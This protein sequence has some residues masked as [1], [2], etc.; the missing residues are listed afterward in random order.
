M[1]GTKKKQGTDVL[2][3]QNDLTTVPKTE[4]QRLFEQ[5]VLPLINKLR[6]RA[7]DLGFQHFMFFQVEKAAIVE[8]FPGDVY[9]GSVSAYMIGSD[10]ASPLVDAADGIN[11]ALA[12]TRDSRLYPDYLTKRAMEGSGV[13]LPVLVIMRDRRGEDAPGGKVHD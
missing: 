2:D 1:M 3:I 12:L 13:D 8:D 10:C 11:D 9:T 4:R 7:K 6:E 5:E